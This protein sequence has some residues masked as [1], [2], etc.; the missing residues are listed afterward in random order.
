MMK[1]R[2]SLNSGSFEIFKI[3]QVQKAS[4]ENSDWELWNLQ[5]EETD[6]VALTSV[7]QKKCTRANYMAELW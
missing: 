1:S 2:A 3:T 6:M 7:T 4:L 5:G